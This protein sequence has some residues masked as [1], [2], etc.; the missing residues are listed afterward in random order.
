VFSR[1][2]QD[3]PAKTEVLGCSAEQP[4]ELLRQSRYI[5]RRV[6]HALPATWCAAPFMARL[7]LPKQTA[8]CNLNDAITATA[9]PATR[10]LSSELA[11]SRIRDLD[12][13]ASIQ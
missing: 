10:D 12:I 6:Q 9:I 11:V 1:T 8:E 4:P 5:A 13:R 3:V 2:G 7:I